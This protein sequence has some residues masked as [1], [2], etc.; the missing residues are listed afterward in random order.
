MTT[1]KKG[2]GR[3]LKD[4]L[5][6][7]TELR[8]HL[9]HYGDLQL[10]LKFEGKTYVKFKIEGKTHVTVNWSCG[11][12]ALDSFHR[13]LARGDTI[14]GKITGGIKRVKDRYFEGRVV[15]VAK[16]G[17]IGVQFTDISTEAF[18]ALNEAQGE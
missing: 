10:K 1:E 18:R 2:L 5:S 17:H 7:F 11:G 9:R 4:S 8:K 13:P 12:F 3:R 14:E 16:H 15:R 6:S